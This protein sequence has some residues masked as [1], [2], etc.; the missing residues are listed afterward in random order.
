MQ[1]HV[2]FLAI[3]ISTSLTFV[4]STGAASVAA[5]RQQAAQWRADHRII[6]LHQHIN[7]T[8]Q[9]LTRAVKIM[10]AVGLGIGVN[11]SG[12]TVTRGT[13][14]APSAFERNKQ[15]ADALFPGRFLHYFNLDYKGWDQPDFSERARKQVEEAHRLGA[16]GLKEFKRLG[17]NLRDG[18][19]KLIKVDDPKLDLVWRRC[20]ELGMPVSI[21][22]GDPKAFW[23]P[24][25]NKNERWKELKDH[26]PWWFGDTNIYP[27]RMDIVNALDRVIAKHRGTTFVCVHFANN[28]EDIEW[29]DQALDRNPNMMADLA[30]RIPEVGRHKP[31][32]VHNLF[33]KH[34]DRIV[35]ATDFQVYDKL[36]LGSSGDAERPTDRDAEIFYEKEWRWL[37]TW[38]KNWEHM[39]P[40][41]GDW[42][43]SSIGLPAPVLRKIY[44]DNARKL[45][46]RS[47]PPPTLKAARVDKDFELDGELKDTVW[48][49]AVPTSLE[50]GSLKYDARP[51]LTTSVRALYSDQFIYFGWECPF[52]TLT[53]FDTPSADR[54]RLGLWDRD[55]VE[56]FV[57]SEWKNINRYAEYEVAPTNERL[58]VLLNL[59]GKDFGWDGRAQSAVKVDKRRKVWTVEWRMPLELLA[60][61][62]P[63]PGTRWRL[64]LY[65]CDKANNAY[66]AWSPVLKGS[67]HTPEKFGVLEF[68]E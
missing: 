14:D 58:D 31:R 43:I 16:A 54:E 28:P 20:G 64:N 46:A 56:V 48:Q 68:G 59:P 36:I 42:T 15:R 5:V 35:F 67:F 50:Y 1:R 27:P 65:R 12:G 47:L 38:D 55:V 8:T 7:Y 51:E 41:Q 40:I 60:S 26:R 39:T 52:T 10:D 4:D 23:L 24:F 21:H 63:A 29:V 19:G 9:H 17:L 6:D 49:K 33:V 25:D 44:F 57:G 2:L 18:Q 53:V 66:L 3:F 32:K 11:L 62:K 45:L 13:N 22:V 37:E 61:A 30:A 34:Q